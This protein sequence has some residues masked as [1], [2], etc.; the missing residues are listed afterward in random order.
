LISDEAVSALRD[1][2]IPLAY[3]V[4]PNR[5]EA[6]IL[7]A[8]PIASLDDMQEAAVRIAALG[9]QAVLVKGGGMGDPLRSTDVFF[10]D[11]DLQILRAE[12]VTTQHTH[13]TGCTLSA[14][15]TA[16]LAR[17]ETLATAIAGA[18]H[19]VTEALHHSL[20]IGRG[21]GP[22]GHFYPLLKP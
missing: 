4:T 13:G 21:R 11:G 1:K 2:L 15:I 12:T 6:A 20:V 5:H 3:L 7:A 9:C 22:V 8:M 19:Y 16:R 10:K 17:S 18:K 14:A